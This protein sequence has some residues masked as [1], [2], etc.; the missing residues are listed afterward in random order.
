MTVSIFTL[1]FHFQMSFKNISVVLF[2]EEF[3]PWLECPSG[4]SGW[5]V[6]A[7]SFQKLIEN[8]SIKN[9]ISNS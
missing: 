8:S 3:C 1:L 2:S 5:D 7:S 4:M 6:H 9:F